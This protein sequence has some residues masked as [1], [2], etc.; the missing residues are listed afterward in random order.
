MLYQKAGYPIIYFG[1]IITYSHRIKAFWGRFR[2]LQE[3]YEQKYNF[4]GVFLL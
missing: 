4:R 2:T 1:Y 3:I